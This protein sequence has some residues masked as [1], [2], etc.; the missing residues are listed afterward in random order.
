M[1]PGLA[2]LRS[3]P[4]L[5]LALRKAQPVAVNEAGQPESPRFGRDSF[6]TRSE[7]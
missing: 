3:H 1:P 6:E 2:P 4:I 7:G 5:W